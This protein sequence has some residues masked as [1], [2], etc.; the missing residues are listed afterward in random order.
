MP[1]FPLPMPEAA[2]YAIAKRHLSSDEAMRRAYASDPY[3]ARVSTPRLWLSV[4]NAGKA[5]VDDVAASDGSIWPVRGANPTPPLLRVKLAGC[6][7]LVRPGSDVA[8]A[9]AVATVRKVPHGTRDPNAGVAENTAVR[10]EGMQH[11]EMHI[12]PSKTAIA[13][14]SDDMDWFDACLVAHARNEGE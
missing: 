4:D 9:E 1:A 7:T 6:E 14:I 8:I 11:E 5:L 10:Y 2:A 3:R 12:A 13:C